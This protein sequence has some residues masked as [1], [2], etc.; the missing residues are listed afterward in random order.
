MYEALPI[1][2]LQVPMLAS[3]FHAG[4]AFTDP[5]KNPENL[6]QLPFSCL[7]ASF[8]VAGLAP[9]VRLSSTAQLFP[10]ASSPAMSLLLCS[11]SLFL[12]PVRRSASRYKEA[13]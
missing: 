11:S 2:L 8:S 4:P 10:P 7:S 1:G 13:D 9:W 5:A 12:S 6:P 3:L